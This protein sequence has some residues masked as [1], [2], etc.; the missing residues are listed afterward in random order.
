MW[1]DVTTDCAPPRA[2]SVRTLGLT[3]ELAD[4]L[5]LERPDDVAVGSDDLADDLRLVERAAVGERRIGVDQLD[6]RHGVVALA[7]PGLVGLARED[8][9]RRA[10]S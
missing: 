3:F 2:S 1:R 6:R 7:D 4:D 10:S 5:R 8:R 9:L